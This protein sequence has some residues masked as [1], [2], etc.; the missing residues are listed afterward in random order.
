MKFFVDTVDQRNKIV[1]SNLFKLGF[2]TFELAQ[3]D[4][5][6]AEDVF[7]FSP[8]K[9]WSKQ[10]IDDL[11]PKITLFCGKIDEI[12][13][14]TLK[15][16]NIKHINFLDDEIFAIKNANLTAE[17]VLALLLKH[18]P[19]S[20]FENK[21]LIFGFG[22]IS[23]ALA[24]LFLKLGIHFEIASFSKKSF[25]ESFFVSNKNFFGFDFVKDIEKFDV[26]VNTR[27]EKFL[28]E[29]ILTKI[30]PNALFLETAS[31][32]CLDEENAKNFCFVKAPSLPQI[33]CPENA[34]KV[35]LDKILGE[36]KTWKPILGLQ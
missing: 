2:E 14:K 27:P 6:N 36:I 12:F 22:R 8:A 1:K 21:I 25:E 7:V 13:A 11:T 9:R 31:V 29:S 4:K 20:I 19:K 16:K 17:G 3:K 10:E 34:A 28:D 5:A 24:I 23:K 32:A 18:S 15:D 26:F 30:Q 33:F 35:V